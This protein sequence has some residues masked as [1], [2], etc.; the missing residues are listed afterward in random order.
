MTS[1]FLLVPGIASCFLQI[2]AR[3]IKPELSRKWSS[4]R[5]CS[6]LFSCHGPGSPYR[7]PGD[8]DMIEEISRVTGVKCTA[9]GNVSKVFIPKTLTTD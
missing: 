3:L 6:F 2:R 4:R 9:E 7:Q 8:L 5:E 1:K